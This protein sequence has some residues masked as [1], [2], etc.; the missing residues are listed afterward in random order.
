MGCEAVV[1]AVIFVVVD[2][3]DA[4]FV[5]VID[6][7]VSSEVSSTIADIACL[8]DAWEV[9]SENDDDTVM[10]LYAFVHII[11]ESAIQIIE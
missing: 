5:S 9:C 7:F 4:V 10:V 8:S 1:V 6:H 3:D 2:V 11:D